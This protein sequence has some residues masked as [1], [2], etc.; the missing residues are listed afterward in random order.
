MDTQLELYKSIVD[1]AVDAIFLGDEKGN[2]IIVNKSAEQLTGYTKAELLK[3]NMS[4]LFPKKVLEH[5]PL[6]YDG[7]GKSKT[8]ITER[9]IVRKDGSL[10]L[11]EMKSKKLGTSNYQSFIRDISERKQK[12]KEVK[13]N[14]E[15]YKALFELSP[16]GILIEDSKGT[17]I[18]ANPLIH[19]TF[20]YE[21]NNLIGK[22]INIIAHPDTHNQIQDNI[23]KILAGKTLNH[24]VRN[25]KKDG[26][27]V[28]N[29]L[30]ETKIIL[31][32]I[33]DGILSISNDI[34]KQVLAERKLKANEL[35]YQELF[36]YSPI[37]I[38]EEDVTELF[39]F[40]DKLKESGINDLR[41][42]FD[43]NSQVVYN[44]IKKIK[45][46]KM[47]NAGL[48][49]YEFKN[50]DEFKSNFE[51]IFTPRSI[52]VFKEQLIAFSK[53]FT[54]FSAETETVTTSGERKHLIMKIQLRPKN[55]S[56]RQTELFSLIDITERKN[57]SELLK[58]YTQEIETLFQLSE[59][60]ISNL[61]V[62]EII[63]AIP[64][65]IVQA[66]SNTESASMWKYNKAKDNFEVV[67][68]FGYGD[69]KIKGFVL[70]KS[71]TLIGEIF[72]KKKAIV[73]NDT[74]KDKRYKKG[75]EERKLKTK[76]TLGVPLLSEN[77]VHYIIFADNFTNTNVFENDDLKI[78]Q[79]FANIASITINK[80]QF[81]DKIMESEEKYRSIF[82]SVGESIFIH[83]SETGKIIDVNKN[84]LEDYGFSYDEALCLN[85]NDSS[86]G[87][88][89]YT[90]EE[91][92]KFVQKA[93]TDGP[94]LF[95]WHAKNKNGELFWTEV[96]LREFK[97]GKDKRIVAAVRDIT[98]RKIK[99]KEI[100]YQ[101]N[102]L[103]SANDAIIASFDQEININLNNS[104][105]FWNKGAEK[106]LGW[107]KEEVLGKNI[108][109]VIHT[110]I[111][112]DTFEN[113]LEKINEIGF[114]SGETIQYDK[115]GDKKYVHLSVS[116]IV[117]NGVKIGS[118]GVNHDITERKL[119]EDTIKESEAK[120]NSIMR[121]AP[122][123]I[124]FIRNR[125]LEFVNDHL[126]SL[127]GYTKEEVIGKNSKLFY[128]SLEQ[129]DKIG[130]MY[131]KI[132]NNEKASDETRIKNK[133]G[134][135]LDVIITLSPLEKED[136]TKGLVF[137]VLDITEKKKSERILKLEQLRYENLF[138]NSPVPLW[139]E[140]FTEIFSKMK[141]LKTEGV[142]DLGK[143]FISNPGSITEFVKLTNVINVNEAT[144]EL[145]NSKNKEELYGSLQKLFT[146]NS[147][148]M[149]KEE[150]IAIFDG[151]KYFEG[152]GEVRTLDDKTKFIDIRLYLDYN[153][154]SNK[155]NYTALLATIDITERKEHEKELQRW[156][157]VFKHSKWGIVVGAA[158][159]QDLEIL[160]PAFAE[161]HGYTVE[162]LVGK[163]ADIVFASNEKVKLPGLLKDSHEKGNIS[164]ESEHLRKDGSSF[165]TLANVSTIKDSEGNVQHRI[166]NV[167][168]IT[169]LK[170]AEAIIAKE[171]DQ[172]QKYL[173]IAGVMF[174]V[175]DINGVVTLINKKG[176]EIFGYDEKEII[177][178]NWFDFALPKEYLSEVKDVFHRTMNENLKYVE[179]YENPIVSKNGQI[180]T[181]AFHNTIL[182][183]N[184]SKITGVLFSG[185][186]ITLQKETLENLKKSK[187]EIAELAQHLQ[188]IREEERH[189][190]AT[191]IHDDLG[192]SLTALKLDASI[193]LNK[194]ADADE[195]VTNKIKSMRDLTNQTIRT[196]QKIS[197]ELRPGI[198]DDLGLAA[199]IEWETNKFEERTN[200]NCKLKLTPENISFTEKLNI[201]VFRLFQ[202]CCTNVARHSN[203]TELEININEK[204]S[205]LL[206]QIKDNGIGI[207]KEQINSSKSFGLVGMRERLKNLRGGINFASEPN[208]GTIVNIVIPLK[209]EDQL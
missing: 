165:P 173:D 113:I 196:V 142:S 136:L 126:L 12:E 100:Y 199:A 27:E 152:E 75:S 160:N 197:S 157:D 2:F 17:I 201:T 34:T 128:E 96:N 170:E 132:Q 139:E 31:P 109:D 162:E 123:G 116:S 49:L 120:I 125:I 86:S 186:D 169:Q 22:K 206:I 87:V 91:A 135:I 61:D 115:N 19:K 137:S 117:R 147:L 141:G 90:A 198:L 78:L 89:P 48:K 15:K 129:Y 73:C 63:N 181:I 42:Y 77:K 103:D 79:S 76:A 158:D 26:T 82:D 138:E 145:H 146:E 65:Y 94:Q 50:I 47:N 66:S 101:A 88:H 70:P 8:I 150:M 187:E 112:D 38:L 124:G 194:L 110:E 131:N 1:D 51:N 52:E 108:R 140:D 204:E 144:L 93:K 111:L 37:P 97:V 118:I 179:Y 16:T 105:A 5:P 188:D 203:A 23:Q 154:S 149:F 205:K 60:I 174:G 159:K 28:Y 18:A 64:K 3:L 171:R 36:E 175:L 168:D 43:D 192:Q 85:P 72:K 33:G 166:V 130:D 95:E 161:M 74:A 11:V 184:E 176:C 54:T 20:G 53:G 153:Y 80:A 202:E 164:F 62:S 39:A 10:V 133:F 121:G 67:S 151:K 84:M 167:Q 56:G 25:I 13:E 104:I 127:L 207:S 177:G 14:Q 4:D 156:A 21:K 172:A 44:C 122:V 29:E 30:Y 45:P 35:S 189:I 46:L 98:E 71:N 208:K 92:F 6:K 69:R 200:I 102:L 190:M 32:E 57:N 193:L 41:K 107:K 9:E 155:E 143:Y 7:L 148:D 55:G 182:R 59:E 183:G 114:W 191:E 81:Y 209:N 119:I 178:K 180:K 106:L 68:W 83:D 185:E 40:L 134:D 24:I 195:A 99:E 163:P 58:Q